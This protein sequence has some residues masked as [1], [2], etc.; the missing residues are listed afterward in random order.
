MFI[1]TVKLSVVFPL[2]WGFLISKKRWI[3]SSCLCSFNFPSSQHSPSHSAQSSLESSLPL[4]WPHRLPFL[5]AV[6]SSHIDCL[7]VFSNMADMFPPWGF[8]TLYCNVLETWCL[9]FWF[10]VS[11][12]MSPSCSFLWVPVSNLY[13][14]PMPLVTLLFPTLLYL[15]FFHG[16]CH[17]LPYIYLPVYMCLSLPPSGWPFLLLRV[18]MWNLQYLTHRRYSINIVG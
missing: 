5:L 12:Q 2:G 15:F 1:R 18:E 11:S 17:S 6:H 10:L 8:W 16:T 3:W 7:A 4:L 14:K 9:S 13:S